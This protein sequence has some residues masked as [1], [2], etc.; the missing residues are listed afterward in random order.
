MI[1]VDKPRIYPGQF[2]PWSHMF[3]DVYGR[4]GTVELCRMAKHIGLKMQWIQHKGRPT[5][6]FD[7]CSPRVYKKVVEAG[8]VV[9]SRTVLAGIIRRKLEAS[10]ECPSV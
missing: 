9:V 3:S 2:V 5:E 7:I 6:H 8:A 4:D 10:R 1:V